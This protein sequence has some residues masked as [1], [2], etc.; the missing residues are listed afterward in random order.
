MNEKLSRE[1]QQQVRRAFARSSEQG[2]GLA[3]GFLAALGLF[4]A[5]AI[6]LI[7]PSP[8]PPGPHLGLLGVYLPGYSVSWPGAFIGAG[9]AFFLGYGA[10]RT[11]AT[12]Y[13]WV[14]PRS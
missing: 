9:Y 4:L 13:N 6:L 8:Y 11:I 2:W 3:L 10:G 5:T 1:D 14:A 7:K 12:L